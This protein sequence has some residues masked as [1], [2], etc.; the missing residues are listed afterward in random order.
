MLLPP[1]CRWRCSSGVAICGYASTVERAG[2]R[3]SSLDGLRGVAAIVV[4]VHHSFLLVPSL[5]AVYF[6]SGEVKN[7]A[8]ILAYSPLH[9][10]WAG[11]E[12]VYLF[13]VLSGLVLALPTSRVGFEWGGYFPSRLVRLYLPVF[14][15]VLFA[16]ATILLVPR[17]GALDSAWA[18]ARPTDYSFAAVLMDLTLIGGVSGVISPLWSLTY[19][20][21]FS[22]LLPLY[23]A[24]ARS[25]P[26]LLV[27]AG[28]LI[29]IAVGDA[30]QNRILTYLPMFAVGV[31]LAYAWP[32][33]S[34]WANKANARR[35]GWALWLLLFAASWTLTLSTW[36]GYWA[37]GETLEFAR[38]VIVLG[39]TGFVILAAF[40]PL[41]R[42]LLST[43][44]IL[45]L[46][47]VSFSLY[48]THEPVVL[49]MGHM[50]PHN[51]KVAALLA[52]AISFPIAWLFFIA[53]E[54]PTHRL[55]KRV[56][57]SARS[58]EPVPSLR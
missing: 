31:A 32:T 36:F 3:I 42:K 50:F 1:L 6:P 13:F 18:A 5:A 30:G 58:V 27:I 28:S 33:L 49:A 4:L 14:G 19:E 34:S 39:V 35:S 29:T 52:I 44:V 11:T 22:L 53:V 41:A 38:P 8:A 10:G 15:A 46:G 56:L 40:S 26:P 25:V 16:L 55:A 48:L 12:A 23:V 37:M 47:R 24:V 57:N 45:W 21:L 51:E 17:I 9:L 7:S 43:R 20:V 54:R 2:S